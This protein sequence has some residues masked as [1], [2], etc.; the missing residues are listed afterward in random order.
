MIIWIVWFS[1]DLVS[2]TIDVGKHLIAADKH[3][4]QAVENSWLFCISLPVKVDY[5]IFKKN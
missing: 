2:L 1:P 5:F 3:L 4:R